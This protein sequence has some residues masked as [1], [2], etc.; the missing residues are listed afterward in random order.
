MD[1]ASLQ[2]LWL[3]TFPEYSELN[4]QVL[5]WVGLARDDPALNMGLN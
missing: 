2:Y 5:D 4:C 1:P 3:R